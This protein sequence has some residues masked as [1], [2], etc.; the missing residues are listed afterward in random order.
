MPIDAN[1]VT[2]ERLGFD[3]LRRDTFKSCDV[4]EYIPKAKSEERTVLALL[5]S[6]EITP[7]R[8]ISSM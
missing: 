7:F 2:I 6:N 5:F 4:S 3:Q 1:H 8:I